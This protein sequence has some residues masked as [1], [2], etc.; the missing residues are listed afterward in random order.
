MVLVEQGSIIVVLASHISFIL[1]KTMKSLNICVNHF[2][3]R[4]FSKLGGHLN[5]QLSLKK[6]VSSNVP[7][8]E[9]KQFACKYG[10]R[11]L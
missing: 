5:C 1:T 9:R 8:S 7:S 2:F 6:K 3:H 11:C 4:L 10:R